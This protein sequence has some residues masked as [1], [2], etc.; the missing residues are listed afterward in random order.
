MKAALH[1]ILLATII[2]GSCGDS[3]LSPN[4][5][6]GNV[7]AIVAENEKEVNDIKS[8]IEKDGDGGESYIY[9]IK[10]RNQIQLLEERLRH[11]A[12]TVVGSQ[13]NTETDKNIFI[14]ITK[15]MTVE[16]VKTD[17]D[18][19]IA[20]EGEL[21]SAASL[22]EGNSRVKL[23]DL[24]LVFHS[25]DTPSFYAAHIVA[26]PESTTIANGIYPKGTKIK[27][28]ATVDIE[29]WN[30]Y[31][32]AVLRSVTL[33]SRKRDIYHEATLFERQTKIEMEANNVIAEE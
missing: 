18:I 1:S 20:G 19:V 26:T 33:T 6:F 4:G 12:P 29:P 9:E 22:W 24:G 15:P 32:M 17:G 31:H 13:I 28:K 3:Q 8:K 14:T 27:L 23:N 5:P 25:H 10:L 30:A 2:V 16:E 11:T 21:E 7:P